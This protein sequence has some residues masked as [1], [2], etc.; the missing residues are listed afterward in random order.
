MKRI[1]YLTSRYIIKINKFVI[2][3]IKVKKAD[4]HKV[5]SYSKIDKIVEGTKRKKGNVYDKAV[6][7]MRNLVKYHPFSA[8]NRRTAYASVGK[9][10]D[11]NR[12][13]FKVENHN[14]YSRTLTGIREDYYTHKEIKD[15]FKN[16]K[17]KKFVRGRRNKSIY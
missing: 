9:F 16:G 6:Y 17:I 14:K 2:E 8:G 11:K 13:P 10:L 3:N 15:W 4:V 5:L 7:L 1:K 12:K